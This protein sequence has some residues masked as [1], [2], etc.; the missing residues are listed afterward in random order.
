[1]FSGKTEELIRRITR[2]RYAKQQILSFKPDIDQR[3]SKNKITS[4]SGASEQ[5]Y[6]VADATDITDII[7]QQKKGIPNLIAIE[8]VQFFDQAEFIN[9]LDFL[10]TQ[11]TKVIVAGLDMD[12]T[13][14]PFENISFAMGIANR[15][16]KLSAVCVE[17]GADATMTYKKTKSSQRVEIGEGDIYEA[18]CYGC[19]SP[20]EY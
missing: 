11:S 15:I 8:E 6:S 4:H 17:C 5:C 16:D 7:I 10:K 1:M 13:G 20:L 12:F 14:V 18:R 19:W 9:S 2:A 3:Y